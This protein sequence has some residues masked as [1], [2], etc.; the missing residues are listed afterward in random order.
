MPVAVHFLAGEPSAA[1]WIMPA[2]K[3]DGAP[4]C[5]V[6]QR[7]R[8][9]LKAALQQRLVQGGMAVIK[10][11]YGKQIMDEENAI[12]AV[13]LNHMR[14]PARCAEFAPIL[15]DGRCFCG[16]EMDQNLFRLH[17]VIGRN[18]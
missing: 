2:W 15:T 6:T 17:I 4:Y 12:N 13:L 10:S 11:E 16:W 8:S 14:D 7:E 18:G 1:G 3:V 9:A 5:I